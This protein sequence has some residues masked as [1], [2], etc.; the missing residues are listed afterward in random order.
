MADT[1]YKI[2][3]ES[4]NETRFLK[5]IKDEAK[6]FGMTRHTLRFKINSNKKF[7]RGMEP[8]M[9]YHIGIESL[10][11]VGHHLVQVWPFLKSV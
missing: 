10:L 1:L 11:R 2:K 3:T 7:Y 6:H 9:I 4:S 8:L 5:T